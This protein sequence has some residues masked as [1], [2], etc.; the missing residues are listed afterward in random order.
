MIYGMQFV[1]IGNC[2]S[3]FTNVLQKAFI[4]F[5]AAVNV[6]ALFMFNGALFHSFAASLL[7]LISL[8]FDF[9]LSFHFF[10]VVALID[11]PWVSLLGLTGSKWNVQD[12]LFVKI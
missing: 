9:A 4:S 1:K 3:Q 12:S 8:A 7:Q 6:L 11:L 5:L 10:S 2:F